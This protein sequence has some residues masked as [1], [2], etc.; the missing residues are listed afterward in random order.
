MDTGSTC[1]SCDNGYYQPDFGQYRCIPCGSN[2]DTNPI[3]GSISNM[4]CMCTTLYFFDFGSHICRPC[5]IGMLCP[6]NNVVIILPGY[7]VQATPASMCWNVLEEAQRVLGQH[8]IRLRCVA[9]DTRVHCAQC[10]IRAVGM[11]TS[12][13][14]VSNARHKD[15]M[16]SCCFRCL[17][18]WCCAFTDSSNS[19]Q[20][21]VSREP[22]LL[23]RW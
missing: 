16:D 20:R 8:R 22:M 11:L 10:V 5:E 15:G 23:G 3:I 6:G 21:Q 13:I 2:Q 9:W 1:I 14:P 19:Q 17:F 4:S 18:L 12:A 7:G